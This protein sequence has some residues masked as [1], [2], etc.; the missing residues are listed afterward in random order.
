MKD[1]TC[2]AEGI[3]YPANPYLTGLNLNEV[4][5]GGTGSS[6]TTV[7]K[8]AENIL[9]VKALINKL[10]SR[11]TG[12]TAEEIDQATAFDNFM[13]AEEAIAFGLVDEIKTI[14]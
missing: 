5:V 7:K 12:K 3:T 9:E 2:L 8:T 6:A 11:H 13:N 4:I 1:I 10:L 14:I